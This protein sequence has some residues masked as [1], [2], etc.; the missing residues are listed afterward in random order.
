MYC[1]QLGRYRKRKR[2]NV[3]AEHAH[4]V[5]RPHVLHIMPL[6]RALTV[7]SSYDKTLCCVLSF[8]PNAS[9]LQS[10]TT[11]MSEVKPVPSQM[12][13]PSRNY[14]PAGRALPAATNLDDDGLIMYDKGLV[15]IDGEV[16][17]M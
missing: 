7:N 16:K 15:S 5:L 1:V 6:L 11:T 8:A 13:N 3:V 17:K 2:K 4:V 12:T 10:P 14:G 9:P